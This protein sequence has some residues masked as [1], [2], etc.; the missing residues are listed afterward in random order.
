M[1]YYLIHFVKNPSKNISVFPYQ[2]MNI[3]ISVNTNTRVIN[4]NKQFQQ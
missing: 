1:K 4:F 3:A 2:F